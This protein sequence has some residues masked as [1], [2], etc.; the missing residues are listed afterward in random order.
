MNGCLFVFK[1]Y[2]C[3]VYAFVHCGEGGSA[4]E[5]L[6]RMNAAGLP[7]AMTVPEVLIKSVDAALLRECT[8]AAPTGRL[9][10]FLADMAAAGLTP[11]RETGGAIV[12]KL[13]HSHGVHMALGAFHSQSFSILSESHK[14]SLPPRSL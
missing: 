2:R 13:A 7:P 6:E 12:R 4:L 3:A 5:I 11:N 14:L 10:Q 8:A 9:Q 1:T